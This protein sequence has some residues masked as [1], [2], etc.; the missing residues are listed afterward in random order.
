MTSA[1]REVIQIVEIQQPFCA[2][3]FGTSPCTATG[4]NDTKCYNTRATCRDAENFSL[5]TPLSIYFAKADFLPTLRSGQ[6]A[7]YRPSSDWILADG[8]WDD[9]GV[10]RDADWWRDDADTSFNPDLEYDAVSSDLPKYVIPSLVSVSTSPA[11]VNLASSNASAQGIGNR[12]VCSVSFIDHQ[13]TDRL[14]D[15]YVEGRSWDPLSKARGSFWTRWIAR[16]KYRQNIVIKIYEGYA[17]Q[18]LS[19]MASRQYFMQ[20]ITGPDSSGRVTIQ[21]KD[22]LAKIEERKAQAP[23]A[24]PGVLYEEISAA[25]TSIEVANAVEA[26]YNATGTLRIGDEVL[27]YTARAT[28]ANGITFTGVARGTDSTT[29]SAHDFN[30]GVQQCLRYTSQRP[31]EIV[32]DLLL[33]F[34][35]VPAAYLDTTNWASEALN[36][37]DFYKLSVLLTEPE[38]VSKL[39]SELQEQT[40]FFIWWDERDALVKMQAIRG[41]SEDLETLSDDKNILAGSFSLSE[42][43]R[44]RVSQVWVY[45]DILDPVKSV[46]QADSYRSQYVLADLQSETDL[47]YGEASIRKIFARWLGSDALVQNTATRI[48]NRYSEVPTQ[49]KFRVDAKDR[50]YWI[51][52]VFRLNHYLD[53]DEFGAR[54]E[55]IWTVVSAQEVVPGETIELIVEDTTLYGKVYFIMAD[56]AADYPGPDNLPAKYAYIGNDDGELSDGEPSARIA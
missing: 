30:T 36:Y 18:A 49:A 2:N 24:S 14:V 35:G 26:D 6:R 19:E 42:M 46:S 15:P 29:A 54:R 27:T 12:A 7:I 28:S 8:I 22:V 51:G 39:I 17:G 47:L 13:H 43:P 50:G 23:L 10:W 34:A 40:L 38:S 20:S 9:G 1:G 33:N 52:S 56:D 3:V 44:E 16:N 53:V 55:R 32:E 31:D 4:G 21:G 5:G 37:L 48:I 11:K 41:Y 25:E 45:Y